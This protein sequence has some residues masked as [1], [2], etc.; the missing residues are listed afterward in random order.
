LDWNTGE[1]GVAGCP[2]EEENNES[3]QTIIDLAEPCVGREDAPA[4]QQNGHL[5]SGQSSLVDPDRVPEPYRGPE[6]LVL[7]KR[8]HMLRQ[9]VLYCWMSATQQLGRLSLSHLGHKL[10]QSVQL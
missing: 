5:G 1:D 9:A 4:L 2:D 8:S 7:G 3:D 6:H 10:Q